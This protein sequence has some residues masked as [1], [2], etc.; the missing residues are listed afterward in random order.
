MI[1]SALVSS[2]A[3]TPSVKKSPSKRARSARRSPFC[4]SRSSPIQAPRNS[5][6]RSWRAWGAARRFSSSN[7]S[8]RITSRS[9]ATTGR[10]SFTSTRFFIG[11]EDRGQ[12]PLLEGEDMGLGR[13]PDAD[14]D[15]RPPLLVDLEHVL[16]GP[17]LVEAQD[18]LVHHDNVR[19]QV[20]RVVQDDDAPRGLLLQL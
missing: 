2:N 14:P 4:P 10:L 18:L 17:C 9:G 15:D 11:L 5:W 6:S 16:A 13:L 19:H 8:S 1:G 3:T 12:V 20:H 7:E